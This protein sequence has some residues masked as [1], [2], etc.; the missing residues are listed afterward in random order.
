MNAVIEDTGMCICG[1]PRDKHR[2]NTMKTCK[3]CSCK[4][5]TPAIT[6]AEG[7]IP[8][9]HEPECGCSDCAWERLI[10]AE[11]NLL[12]IKG[13]IE[14]LDKSLDMEMDASTEIEERLDKFEEKQNEIL[15]STDAIIKKDNELVDSVNAIIEL[16]TCPSRKQRKWLSG[17]LKDRLIEP[18]EVK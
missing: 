12:S 14:R 2:D 1:H 5:Y 9:E 15:E 16:L 7:L 4:A 6:A 13:E 11:R 17:R 3:K 18:I 8:K 10:N